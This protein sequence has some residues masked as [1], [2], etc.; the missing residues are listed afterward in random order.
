MIAPR[1]E[2]RLLLASPSDPVAPP[3]GRESLSRLNRAILTDLFGDRFGLF[4]F[5]GTAR[6]SPGSVLRGHIDGVAPSTI[7]RLC[8]R[9]ASDGITDLFL[10]G[11]NL[12]VAA[13]A[14]ARRHPRVRIISFLHN[15][16]AA[17]FAAALRSRP[18]PRAAGVLIANY[19]AEHAAVKASDLVICLSARDSAVLDRLYGRCADA[20]APM[21]L[22]DALP[23]ASQPLPKRDGERFLLFVGGAFYANRDGIRWFAREVAPRLPI[24][25]VVVGRGMEELR[26]EL[27]GNPAVTVIGTTD[28]LAGWYRR[29]ALVIAPI[30]GGSGMKTKVAEALMFGKHVIA[31][32]E[33]LSGYGAEVVAA[34]P[35][36][37]D[38]DGFV[39]AIVAALDRDA[40]PFD[41]AQRDLYVRFH[42]FGAARGRMA[43][44][45]GVAAAGTSEA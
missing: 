37:T 45:L 26:G 18:S 10:D 8:A 13:A 22:A 35:C 4:S 39:A 6:P 20:I 9:I 5:A 29:A 17:F 12:G 7:A 1:P 36:C 44:I 25:T 3:G 2:R 23:P 38:A 15:V 31:T 32:P 14:V 16:E 43:R 40:P 11:S 33:A 27:A 24:G 28:D 19:R 42:S 21:A 34:T 30:F 41:Q